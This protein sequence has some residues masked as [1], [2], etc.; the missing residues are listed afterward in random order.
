MTHKCEE[1]ETATVKVTGGIRAELGATCR[2]ER[3]RGEGLQK[4]HLSLDISHLPFRIT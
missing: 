2:D 4:C 1:V 3:Y